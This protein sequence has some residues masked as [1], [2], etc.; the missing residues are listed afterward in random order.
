M[1]SVFAKPPV[2]EALCEL[3]FASSQERPW[4]HVVPGLLYSAI[5]S[6]FPRRR[7]RPVVDL[8]PRGLSPRT[9]VQLLTED[10]QRFVQVAPD[11]LAVNSLPPHVG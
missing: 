8:S 11:L 9:F 7:D 3:R 4:D 1:A 2:I 6:R 10:E 5:Q